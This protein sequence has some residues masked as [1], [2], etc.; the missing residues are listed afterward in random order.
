MCPVKSDPKHQDRWCEAY[1]SHTSE[2]PGRPTLMNTINGEL[3]QCL[4][5]NLEPASWN[6]II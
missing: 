5:Q 4:S 3:L 6:N 1:E 2:R